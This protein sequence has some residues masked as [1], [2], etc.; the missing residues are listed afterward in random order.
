M[1]KNIAQ[2][3]SPK[4]TKFPTLTDQLQQNIRLFGEE[5]SL[6]FWKHNIHNNILSKACIELRFCFII[7]RVDSAPFN[8]LVF[9]QETRQIDISSR[10]LKNSNMHVGS[11]DRDGHVN[12]L[13]CT[14]CINVSKSS[15]LN[16]YYYYFL[17]LLFNIKY[18]KYSISD[19]IA[20][21]FPRGIMYKST[22]VYIIHFVSMNWLIY[23]SVMYS[24]QLWL[25]YKYT[26][27]NVKHTIVRA[28]VGILSS[29]HYSVADDNL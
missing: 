24:S 3:R 8:L 10:Y 26:Q 25:L 18:G 2:A 23:Q 11:Q 19:F 28:H 4:L 7:S 27:C 6:K 21:V 22:F 5:K 17:T 13:L 14:F 20:E 9:C 1:L 15:D 12:A 29:L 16:C